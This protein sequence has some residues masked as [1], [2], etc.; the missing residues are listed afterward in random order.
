MCRCPADRKHRGD[1][2]LAV[3]K[4][5]TR[6]PHDASGKSA[7]IEALLT[8]GKGQ[9]VVFSDKLHHIFSV[10]MHGKMYTV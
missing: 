6:C 9:A 10:L 5:A 1:S 2:L 8:K 3:H 4:A 7:F